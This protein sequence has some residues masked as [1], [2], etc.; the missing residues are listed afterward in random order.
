MDDYEWIHAKE[1]QVG[2]IVQ[3]ATECDQ[4]AEIWNDPEGIWIDWAS[5]ECGYIY[6]KRYRVINR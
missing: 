6:N 3:F 1:L 4:V 2:D 5:S